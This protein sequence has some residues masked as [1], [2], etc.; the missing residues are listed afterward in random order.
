MASKKLAQAVASG[1]VVVRN[2][3]NAEVQLHVKGNPYQLAKGEK[4]DLTKLCSAKECLSIGGLQNLLRT[5]HLEL[6]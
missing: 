5:G 6:L 1:N 4:L 3:Q 2:R